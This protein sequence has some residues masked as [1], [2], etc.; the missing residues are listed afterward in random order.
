M[1]DQV[2]ICNQAL[3]LLGQDTIQN[4]AENTVEAK[5]C[6]V[7]YDSA[8]DACLRIIKPPFIMARV[9]PGALLTVPLSGLY[10]YAYPVPT[11]NLLILELGTTLNTGQPTGAF[12]DSLV[13]TVE[14]QAIL[15]NQP[16]LWIRY[17]QD[18]TGVETVMDES[19]VL[20]FAAFLASRIAY[21]I[22]ES[23]AKVGGMMQ[24][25]GAL[26]EECQNVYGQGQSTQQTYNTQLL[27]NR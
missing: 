9:A 21:A 10:L 22:T 11:D 14:G 6:S 16:I 26:K 19:F 20:A 17:L 18:L 15:T 8:R 3:M 5:A 2:T 4:L 27:A 24:L 25:Y 23:N 1:T 13:W 12:M 7:F